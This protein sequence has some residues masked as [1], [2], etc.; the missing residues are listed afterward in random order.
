MSDLYARYINLCQET[1]HLAGVSFEL[2]NQCNYRC[3]HCYRVHGQRFLEPGHFR[4][5]LDE[6]ESL[7]AIMVGFNGGEPTIHPL[8]FQYAVSVLQRGM[9][10]SVLSN[11]SGLTD[12]MLDA[13]TRWRLGI[14]LQVSLYGTSPLSGE[15]ITGV[16]DAFEAT[17]ARIFDLQTRGFDLRV[18]LLALEA[19]AE[20]LPALIHGLRERE[21]HIGLIPQISVSENGSTIPLGLRA[22]D[23][24]LLPLFAFEGDWDTKDPLEPTIELRSEDDS[25][26][27]NAGVTSLGIRA[28]GSILPCLICTGPVLGNISAD[29]LESVLQGEARRRFLETNVIPDNCRACEVRRF[30]LRC[31][32]DAMFETGSLTGI[33]EESCRIAKLRAKFHID[34]RK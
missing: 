12:E 25:L 6:A 1:G 30:C 8:F 22:P 2:T 24:H 16:P 32:A 20:G 26:A 17:L 23:D 5:A 27:C 13:L 7:G 10:L 29:T 11:G 9:H 18:S 28:D 4:K 14:H 19:T 31:P 3:S 15:A 34:S 21:I 33:P